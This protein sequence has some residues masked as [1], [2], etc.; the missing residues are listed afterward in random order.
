MLLPLRQHLVGDR[1]R[2]ARRPFGEYPL[3]QHFVLRREIGVQQHDGDRL[4]LT[5]RPRFVRSARTWASSSASMTP[6][7]G[8]IRSSTSKPLRRLT[9][10]FGFT[11]SRS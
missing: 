4:D 1:H 3:D 11:Q 6:P 10:G 9:N 7:E 2:H 5:L 8:P